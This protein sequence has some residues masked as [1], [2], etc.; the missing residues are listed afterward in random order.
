[1]PMTDY[2]KILGV[3]KSASED[4]IKKAFRKKAME[5]HPDRHNGDKELESKFKEVNEA[6]EVLGDIQKRQNYDTF[7]TPDAQ[8]TGSTF[9]SA[10]NFFEEIFGGLGFGSFRQRTE[11]VKQDLK[12]KLS[13]GMQDSFCG[14]KKRAE[15][16]AIRSC[17]SC[18]ADRKKYICK[19][20]NGKGSTIR[21][22]GLMFV[23]SRTCSSCL[24]RG[25]T[26]NISCVFCNN[27]GFKNEKEIVDIFVPKG[28]VTGTTL[29]VAN[30]GNDGTDG[31]GDL[32]VQIVTIPSNGFSISSG[33]VYY[34][35][36]ISI[37]D[38]LLGEEQKI[39]LPDGR[40]T[41][42]NIPDGTRLT[43]GTLRIHGVGL[44]RTNV[45]D[46]NDLLIRIK[47][48]MP[49]I[50]DETRKA[51]QATVKNRKKE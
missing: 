34:D 23:E 25:F 30:K 48:F 39:N 51:I 31:S 2:Y 44:P 26:T 35:L 32:L 5:C 45:A 43:E 33:E 4:E 38:L 40:T 12:I 22:R 7:G 10:N 16:S 19:N 3:D 18:A 15:Y 28:A 21:Q 46:F 27:I 24:G 49:A 13:I 50:D 14:A 9:H 42:F 36:H 29:R 20:C 47:P 1:M 41:T 11:Y 8:P 37:L 6:Y 17:K